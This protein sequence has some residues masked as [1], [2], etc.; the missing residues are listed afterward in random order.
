MFV[1]DAK[2]NIAYSGAIDNSP[3]GS[4]KEGVINYVDNALSELTGG[5]DV[6]TAKTKSYGC[7]VKYAN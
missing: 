7:S 5:K 4:R 6:S 1:I 3:L 2:G